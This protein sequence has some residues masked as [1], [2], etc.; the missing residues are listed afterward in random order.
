[1]ETLLHKLD[2]LSDDSKKDAILYL[3]TCLNRLFHARV[4][5]MRRML[6]SHDI[7][8]DHIHDLCVLE[9]YYYGLINES[10]ATQQLRNKNVKVQPFNS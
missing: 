3:E 10:D 4:Q 7:D 6:E 2:H 5:K 9:M 1:M 8:K